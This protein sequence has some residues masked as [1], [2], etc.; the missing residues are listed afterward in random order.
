MH[1]LS[2]NLPMDVETI[3]DKCGGE[4]K[5]SWQSSPELDALEFFDGRY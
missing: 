1:I 5:K 4:S 2:S 3:I